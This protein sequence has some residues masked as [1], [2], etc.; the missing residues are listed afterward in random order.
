[1]W[2]GETRSLIRWKVSN[3]PRETSRSSD[4]FYSDRGGCRHSDTPLDILL[5]RNVLETVD[6]AERTQRTSA[7]T[8][9]TSREME[10]HPHVSFANLYYPS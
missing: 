4:G 2:L 7:I 5:H 1:M 3:L 9:A 8:W 6:P 10:T